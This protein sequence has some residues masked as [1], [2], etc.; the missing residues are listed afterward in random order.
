MSDHG[1]IASFSQTVAHGLSLYVMRQACAMEV[2]K[3]SKVLAAIGPSSCCT[4]DILQVRKAHHLHLCS[5][6]QAKIMVE[7]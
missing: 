1:L 4:S 6:H 5:P 7:A 2:A 3:A